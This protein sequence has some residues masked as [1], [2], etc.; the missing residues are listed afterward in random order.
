M[1]LS[2]SFFDRVRPHFAR[3]AC[4]FVLLFGVVQKPKEA[5]AQLDLLLEGLKILG[6]VANIGDAAVGLVDI[7]DKVEEIKG[8]LEPV[9]EWFDG[10]AEF[11]RGISKYAGTYHR[12]K[13]LYN[14]YNAILSYYNNLTTS[15]SSVSSLSQG[16]SLVASVL[17]TS[18]SNLNAIIGDLSQLG[19]FFAN[20]QKLFSSLKDPMGDAAM[21]ALDD[22]DRQLDEILARCQTEMSKVEFMMNYESGM[23][24]MVALSHLATGGEF[25]V[26]GFVKEEREEPAPVSTVNIFDIIIGAIMVI[27][28]I[29]LFFRN[30][31]GGETVTVSAVFRIVAVCF[32]VMFFYYL[33]RTFV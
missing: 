15:F 32:V 23:E 26:P 31:L 14:R 16:T 22:I 17:R 25:E 18:A 9:G 21:S 2:E 27:A 33:V 20:A 24:M 4:V 10:M 13:S 11:A 3:L 5:N 30:S 29:Y 8:K 7:F 12:L 28:L 6:D 1:V 19:D